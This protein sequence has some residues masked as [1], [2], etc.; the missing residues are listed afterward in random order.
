MS[1][2][3]LYGRSLFLKAMSMNGTYLES[4]LF[5]PGEDVTYSNLV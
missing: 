5:F 4:K 3:E 2:S 1:S